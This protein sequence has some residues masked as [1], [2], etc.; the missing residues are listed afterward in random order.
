MVIFL[1]VHKF[2]NV[3]SKDGK[4]ITNVLSQKPFLFYFINAV[5]SSVYAVPDLSAVFFFLLFF[6]DITVMVDWV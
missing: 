2:G 5:I 6:T 4:A 3:C 1:K